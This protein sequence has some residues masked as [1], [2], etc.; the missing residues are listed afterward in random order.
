MPRSR[1]LWFIA[2]G[3]L[4]LGSLLLLVWPVVGIGIAASTS[5]RPPDLLSDFEWP[6]RPHSDAFSKAFPTGSQEDALIAWL[7]QE[8]FSIAT[9]RGVAE[10]TYSGVPCTMSFRI[11][12]SAQG[13]VLESAAVAELTGYACL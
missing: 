11:S 8:Q 9:E 5:E 2:L 12:W 4:G 7:E 10:R 6:E 3:L 1:N 13:G